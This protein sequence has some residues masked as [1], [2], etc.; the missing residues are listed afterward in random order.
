MGE[1]VLRSQRKLGG[2]IR[3]L[4]LA[5]VEILLFGVVASLLRSGYKI[6]PSDRNLHAFRANNIYCESLTAQ[7]FR[8]LAKR[9]FNIVRFVATILFSPKLPLC[10]TTL[11]RHLDLYPVA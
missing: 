3:P 7:S 1:M 5:V 11:P 4:E 9:L 6:L 8:R 10:F 2:M